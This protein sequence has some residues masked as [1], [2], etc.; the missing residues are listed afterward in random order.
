MRRPIFGSIASCLLILLGAAAHAQEATKTK[1]DD[2]IIGLSLDI[3]A[4]TLDCS[5]SPNVVSNEDDGRFKIVDK[6]SKAFSGD[7][8]VLR[9][10]GTNRRHFF[11]GNGGQSAVVN[12][13]FDYRADFAK[14]AN[15]EIDGNDVRL[16]CADGK[17]CIDHSLTAPKCDFTMVETSDC[18]GQAEAQGNTLAKMTLTLCSPQAAE[19]FRL[20]F[21]AIVQRERGPEIKEVDISAM[22]KRFKPESEGTQRFRVPDSVSGG[23]LHLRSGPDTDHAIVATIPAGAEDVEVGQCRRAKGGKKPWCK[24]SWR[25]HS[26]WLSSCCVVNAKTGEHPQAH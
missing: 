26:G 16:S 17:P 21:D 5:V 4:K 8:G 6:I 13:Q 14:L 7:T 20:A 3:I 10:V 1:S 18:D 15:A 9:V 24:A 25:G 19:R 2:P 12:R 23:I 22:I 11:D